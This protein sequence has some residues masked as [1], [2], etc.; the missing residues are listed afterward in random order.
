MSTIMMG[1]VL[2]LLPVYIHF[3]KSYALILLL[4]IAVLFISTK[5]LINY[6]NRFEEEGGE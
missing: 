2:A 5:Q 1:M 3:G 6:K 4:A